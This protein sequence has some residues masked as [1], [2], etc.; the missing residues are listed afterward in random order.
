MKRVGRCHH[1]IIKSHHGSN[2]LES[3]TRFVHI[4]EG[5][6]VSL[7]VTAVAH[8]VEVHDPFD[9]TTFHLHDNGGSRLRLGLHQLVAQ[10]PLGNILYLRIDSSYNIPPLF[11]RGLHHIHPFSLYLLT[12]LHARHPLQQRVVFKF[13]AAGPPFVQ[14]LVDATHGPGSQVAERFFTR[15]AFFSD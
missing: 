12:K 6:G 9:L 1:S 7:G 4:G 3:R 2:R 10:R 15:I 13:E 5:V 8:A 11:S 14:I